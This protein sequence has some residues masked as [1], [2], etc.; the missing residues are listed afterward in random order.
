[1]GSITVSPAWAGQIDAWSD[2]MRAAARPETTIYLRTYHVRRL[3][4]AWPDRGPW[5]LGLDDLADWLG[6]FDWAPETRRSYRA[7]LRGF[8]GWGHVTGRIEANPAALLPT[9]S[10]PRGRPRPVPEPVLIDARHAADDRADLMLALASRAGLR[11]G[12]I[13]RLHTRDLVP[14]LDG[15][16]LRVAGKGGRVRLVPLVDELSRLLRELP[17]GHA[18]PGQVDGHLSASHVG[19][20]ISRALPD[21]WTAHTLRHRFASVTYAASRDLR[22]VQELLGHAKPETTARYT[23]V[24]DDAMRAAVNAA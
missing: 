4:A 8:Y 22:A 5:A 14:D 9:V 20:V 12:E 11:R 6:W 7:S 16:S 19:R 18:F 21:Q 23:A 17:A 24:P 3:G 1:M 13:A 10:P 15:W 2:W